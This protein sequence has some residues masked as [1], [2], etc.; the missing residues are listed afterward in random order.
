[1]KGTSMLQH[2]I[3]VHLALMF[4][5]SALLIASTHLGPRVIHIMGWV[6][7]SYVLSLLC[8]GETSLHEARMAS[9][10]LD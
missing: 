10:R 8:T 7:L 2:S 4:A 3:S 6:Y 9:T 5:L 1:M